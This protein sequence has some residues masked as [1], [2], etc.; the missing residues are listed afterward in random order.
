MTN[1]YEFDKQAVYAIRVLGVLDENWQ[2]WFDGFCISRQDGETWLHGQVADQ[3]A[4]LGYLTKI[5]N[6]SLTLIS[7]ERMEEHRP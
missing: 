1:G 6:L 5:I 3:T 7:V 2:D 4:L